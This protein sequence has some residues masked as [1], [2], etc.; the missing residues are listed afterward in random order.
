MG[1]S[2]E[3][4]KRGKE[5]RERGHGCGGAAWGLLWA[6]RTARCGRP[7][8]TAGCSL[9]RAEREEGNWKEEGE[10]RRKRKE[11]M[12]KIKLENFQKIKDN[13]WSLP[14]IIFVQKKLYV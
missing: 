11:K 2:P 14:K 8:S 4:G 9:L 10:R 6:A 5:K 13:L 1:S 7:C 3:C 12:E